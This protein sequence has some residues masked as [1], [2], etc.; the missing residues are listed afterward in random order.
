MCIFKSTEKLFQWEPGQMKLLWH[1][2]LSPFMYFLIFRC[3]L[4]MSLGPV[5]SF[6]GWLQQVVSGDIEIWLTLFTVPGYSALSL[7]PGDLRQSSLLSCRHRFNFSTAKGWKCWN[8]KS[9][10]KK[11]CSMSA[12]SQE[13]PGIYWRSCERQWGCWRTQTYLSKKQ[14]WAKSVDE[15]FEFARKEGVLGIQV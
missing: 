7:S 14:S 11:S 2:F 3:P 10:V 13:K 5:S 8:I 1:A 9:S 4:L 12:I 15:L 6:M